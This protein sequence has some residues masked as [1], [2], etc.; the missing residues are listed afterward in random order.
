MVYLTILLDGLAYGMVLFIISV[1]LTVT[2]GLMRVINLAHGAFAAIGGYISTGLMTHAGVAF[3]LAVVVAALAVGL[4]GIVIERI[5]FVH[6]YAATALEQV[7]STVGFSFLVIGAITLV[8]G[9]DLYPTKLPPY[10]QGSVSLGFR[11]F[12]VYRLAAGAISAAIVAVLWIIFDRTNI[13]AKLRA[14]VDNPGMT[15]AIG[16]DVPRLFSLTFALGTGLAALGGAIGAPMLPLEPFY[17]FKYLVL[18]LI[19]V[20]LAGH[21]NF[22]GAV[23]VA[24]IIGIIET[25]VRLIFPELGSFLIYG[26]LIVLIVWRRDGL[27]ATRSAA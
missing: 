27:F 18:V 20:S 1:G 12:E 11:D 21:G 25:A 19:I 6:L 17:P 13:G 7:L 9:P 26:V 4:F 5:Y 2:M 24:I 10:L 16:I 14:A 15:Q 8:F 23:G 3:P 22:K